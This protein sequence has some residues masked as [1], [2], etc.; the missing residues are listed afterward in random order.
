M[1]GGLSGVVARRVGAAALVRWSA[2]LAAAGLTIAL[3]TRWPALAVAGF[4]VVGLGLANLV[5]VFFGSA[6]RLPGQRAG[7]E[8]AA[9]ASSADA[10]DASERAAGSQRNAISRL[11]RR[12]A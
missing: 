8:I 7:N 4:A 1:R 9:V 2:L 12:A 6:G 10:T 3:T 11:R 5:P